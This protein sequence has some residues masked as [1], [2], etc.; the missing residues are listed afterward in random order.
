MQ[1]SD[2]ENIDRISHKMDSLAKDMYQIKNTFL[3]K[4]KV[5]KKLSKKDTKRRNSLKKAQSKF[6][7]V[8][9]NLKKDQYDKFEKKLKELKMNKSAYLKKL[10]LDDLGLVENEDLSIE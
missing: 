7:N 3:Q 8:S 5:D 10:I 6:K 2:T 4:E 1:I 9:T